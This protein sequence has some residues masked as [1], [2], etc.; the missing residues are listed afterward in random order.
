MLQDG[1]YDTQLQTLDS[2]TCPSHGLLP[3]NAWLPRLRAS[4]RGGHGLGQNR[5]PQPY[6]LSSNGVVSALNYRFLAQQL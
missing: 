1:M 5:E 3:P 4:L 6:I 2:F